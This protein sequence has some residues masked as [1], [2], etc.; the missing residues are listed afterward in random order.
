MQPKPQ[1]GHPPPGKQTNPNAPGPI[2]VQDPMV[3]P[4][5]S[6][7]ALQPPSRLVRNTPNIV[8]LGLLAWLALAWSLALGNPGYAAGLAPIFLLGPP[9]LGLVSLLIFPTFR[10][11]VFGWDPRSLLMLNVMR[12][13]G[14]GTLVL[15]WGP[16]GQGALKGFPTSWGV[17]EGFT[18][19]TF[20]GI[21][22]LLGVRG[23]QSVRTYDADVDLSLKKASAV[24]G[25]AYR[26]IPWGSAVLILTLTLGTGLLLATWIIVGLSLSQV[27]ALFAFPYSL[28]PLFVIPF[29]SF[30]DTVALSRLIVEGPP[31]PED[32]VL[33][34]NNAFSPS[35]FPFKIRY[36]R[37]VL[38]DWWVRV[39]YRAA[40]PYR[41]VIMDYWWE[42]TARHYPTAIQTF[43][44]QSGIA[45]TMMNALDDAMEYG[46]SSRPVKNPKLHWDPEAPMAEGSSLVDWTN[47][48]WAR[49]SEPPKTDSY[50]LR[51]SM[52]LLGY[53]LN[54]MGALPNNV[55]LA[56]RVIMQAVRDNILE[57]GPLRETYRRLNPQAERELEEKG[58]RA[59]AFH[60]LVAYLALRRR[61]T[62]IQAS[63]SYLVLAPLRAIFHPVAWEDREH[64]MTRVMALHDRRFSRTLNFFLAPVEAYIV[65]AVDQA[66]EGV[67]QA[68]A[69][70]VWH[71]WVEAIDGEHFE[72]V[73]D[74]FWEALLGDPAKG[75]V[76]S[77]FRHEKTRSW[78]NFFADWKHPEIFW[79]DRRPPFKSKVPL[80]MLVPWSREKRNAIFHQ[81]FSGLME[82]VRS[83]GLSLRYRLQA[84]GANNFRAGW[85]G[86][87]YDFIRAAFFDAINPALEARFGR[88]D[89]GD[90][91]YPLV[92]GADPSQAD[93]PIDYGLLPFMRITWES[94]YTV[95]RVE[96]MTGSALASGQVPGRDP[97][98]VTYVIDYAW[99]KRVGEL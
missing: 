90:R 42:M 76:G 34:L 26:G 50:D 59:P 6:G 36:R 98:E 12:M 4:N 74:R 54:L 93:R 62:R 35:Q 22:V 14:F 71:T 56:P 13:A 25:A 87:G 41:G 29:L 38:K 45:V 78:A 67:R 52:Y 11:I 48:P 30:V 92:D 53:Q 60:L 44:A 96:V 61:L 8:W 2:T 51:R 97:I 1:D 17:V 23:Y 43:A 40:R 46:L 72:G 64:F 73:A 80:E 77:L 81:F 10:Q 16:L 55:A 89:E 94:M 28:L 63:L 57:T 21:L 84:V 68:Q 83:K 91:I 65:Y 31:A 58:P 7:G 88:M 9:L 99:L 47:M 95:S 79:A 5:L 37:N 49:T 86:F 20:G 33:G 70:T 3:G 75:T 69:D 32:P 66:V 18:D 19:I 15:A 82:E 27:R 24:R 85:P 39:I